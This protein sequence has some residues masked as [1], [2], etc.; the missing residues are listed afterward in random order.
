MIGGLLELLFPQLEVNRVLPSEAEPDSK[1]D[2]VVRWRWVRHPL[3]KKQREWVAERASLYWIRWF[4]TWGLV[5]AASTK[6]GPPGG[7]FLYLG[8]TFLAGWTLIGV[9]MASALT[10]RERR[11][12]GK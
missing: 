2:L 5:V 1:G 7:A 6:I 11:R 10:R 3:Q 4:I 8:F 9:A 12:T